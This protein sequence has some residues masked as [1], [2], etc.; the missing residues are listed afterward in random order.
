MLRERKCLLT[1]W[2]SIAI[3]IGGCSFS[4]YV[5]PEYP[6][7]GLVPTAKEAENLAAKPYKFEPGTTNLQTVYVPVESAR[8]YALFV[9][10]AYLTA[11]SRRSQARSLVNVAALGTALAALGLGIVGGDETAILVTG[12]VSAGLGI[13]GQLLLTKDHE[14]AYSL[15]AKAVGCVVTAATNA[16]P[17]SLPL[18]GVENAVARLRQATESYRAAIARAEVLAKE[19]GLYADVAL[20]A[21]KQVHLDRLQ[22][23]EARIDV[24]ELDLRLGTRFL[25]GA[26]VLGEQLLN[27]V[28]E[29]RWAVNDAVRRA[30]PD[31]LVLN[32]GLRSIVSTRLAAFGIAVPKALG[33]DVQGVASTINRS[34]T[35]GFPALE[36]AWIEA[37]KSA[38]AVDKAITGLRTA[39]NQAGDRP[40]RFPPDVFA[41]C[42]LSE[43]N[44]IQPVSPPSVQPASLTIPAKKQATA[45][46]SIV[47]GTPPFGASAVGLTGDPSVSG[48]SLAVPISA[49][50][51]EPGRSYAVTVVDLYGNGA[52]FTIS[53]AGETGNVNEG[54]GSGD[55]RRVVNSNPLLKSE[56]V[57]KVQGHLSG[58]EADGTMGEQ[59]RQAVVAF[60][61]GEVADRVLVQMTT[62]VSE[63]GPACQAALKGLKPYLSGP[64]T[65]ERSLEVALNGLYRTPAEIELANELPV[66]APLIAYVSECEI[67]DS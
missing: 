22:D 14:T 59:T 62:P 52:P 39:L 61:K 35:T 60:L 33:D 56:T 7:P 24:A 2:L 67:L 15:G 11:L 55:T 54:Q 26:N 48:R 37:N 12:L 27:K 49:A 19:R 64:I 29:I 45:N 38:A 3:L 13:S 17:F 51:A 25:Q 9:Q 23:A 41:G 21:A 46:A 18:I 50:E 32:D 42:P 63:R 31:V 53:V 47:G 20:G 8:A 43:I 6:R 4:P 28:E 1:V 30:E 66:D 10:D 58:V 44:A 34:A 40:L 36:S 5:Q 16:R 57:K 65:D